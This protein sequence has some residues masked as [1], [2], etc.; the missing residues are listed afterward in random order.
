MKFS[1]KLAALGAGTAVLAALATPALAGPVNVSLTTGGG[2]TLALYEP[3]G[4]TPLTATN[5][6]SG[7]SNFI[8]QVA[9]SGYTNGPFTVQATMS[10]LYSYAGAS[11]VC[12]SYIPSSAITLSSPSGLLTVGGVSAAAT[13][14]FTMTGVLT[15]T[16]L[17][18]I[19]SLSP[20]TLTG[21]TVDGVLPTTPISQSTLTGSSATNLFGST[22][23]G[24]ESQLPVN[25]S[26]PSAGG[27][28][29]NPDVHPTC[30]PSVTSTPTPVQ[31]M[32]GAANPAGLLNDLVSEITAATCSATGT[33]VA[34]GSTPTLS[35]LICAGYLTS[36]AVS[37]V[38]QANTTLMTDLGG[39]TG[40]TANLATIESN[41]T[42]SVSST[43]MSLLA[44]ATTQSGNYS[45]SPSLAV[46]VPSTASGTYKG[47]MTVTLLDS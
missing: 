42:A 15:N 45:S 9:D 21:T 11:Y 20:V 24:V 40:L 17:P 13:P 26:T 30:D 23:S 14:V 22:L 27:A 28:F 25:L 12:S 37:T 34:L 5:L 19:P 4:T 3:D 16:L 6:T 7:S 1:R 18:L 38:L 39:L 41:I 33:A 29:T 35:Q 44:G 43:A 10:N 31:I 36:S 8:A 46:T 32:H 2:R 47:L